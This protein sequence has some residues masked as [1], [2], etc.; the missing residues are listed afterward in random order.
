MMNEGIYRVDKNKRKKS[1]IRLPNLKKYDQ[2]QYA[3][4]LMVN[5]ALIQIHTRGNSEI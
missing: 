5:R 3:H 2:R 4:P 1:G